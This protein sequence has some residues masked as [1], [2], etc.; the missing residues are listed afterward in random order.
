MN[1]LQM[2][3][4]NVQYKKPT[5]R[6][7]KQ[8]KGLLRYYTYRDGRTGSAMQ[9]QGIDRWMDR[10]LGRSIKDIA[11]HCNT[12]KSKHVLAWTLV[13]NPNPELVQMVEADRREQFVHDLTETTLERFF[14]ARAIDTGVEYSYVIHHRDSKDKQSPGL[15]DPHAHILLPGTYFDEGIGGRCPLYFSR[16]RREN[17]IEMLHRSAEGVMMELMDQ[18]AGRDWER[19]Y[20]AILAERRS[21]RAVTHNPPNGTIED[22][23][24]KWN[25]WLGTRMTDRETSAVGYFR[26]FPIN[27][28]PQKGSYATDEVELKFRPI[29]S[30]LPYQRAKNILREL[31]QYVQEQSLTDLSAFLQDVWEIATGHPQEL[32]NFF[33]RNGLASDTRDEFLPES[34][35]VRD[36]DIGM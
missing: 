32:V 24:V 14:E 27:P 15:P 23:G 8:M 7:H 13:I 35:Q 21:E 25:A 1:H 30:K 4:A 3:V 34:R 28:K 9:I 5:G 33:S 16:N 29:L 18:Y 12:F 20:D 11:R 36:L 2:V 17:H 19:D 22:R 31:E 26:Y 10:G 6:G